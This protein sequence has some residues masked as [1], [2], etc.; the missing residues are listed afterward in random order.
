MW[1]QNNRTFTDAF[2]CEMSLSA[3][4]LQLYH[5]IKSKSPNY[6]LLSDKSI[7]LTTFHTSN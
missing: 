6:A 4:D 3:T 5:V 7:N 2:K 1:L